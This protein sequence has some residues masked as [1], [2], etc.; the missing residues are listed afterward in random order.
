MS[1]CAVMLLI[2]V[3]MSFGQNCTQYG[4]ST[5][6]AG[7][8]FVRDESGY[9]Q[10]IALKLQQPI[11]TSPD[12]RKGLEW[13]RGETGV[14]EVQA[15]VYGSDEVSNALRDR[16]ER[17]VG[18]QV[19][20]RGIL[21]PAQT[22]YHHTNVQVGVESVD[23]VDSAGQTALRT[24]TA[25]FQPKVVAAYEVTIN[26]ASRLTVEA[27]DAASKA[28]LIPAEEY[29]PHWMTGGEVVYANCLDGYER[30][31]ISTTD[32]NG[33]ICFDDDLCGFS[34]FPQKPIIIKFRCIK[35]P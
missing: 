22:G 31:L 8:L 7:R 32:K 17:L 26:A 5:S 12:R 9:N 28:P 25:K 2:S 29:A 14:K 18:H 33:G 4:T 3:A 19:E 16:L 27:Q 15:G 21:F 24:P 34:A 20:L 30:K 1:K 23:P 13:E 11:C 6:L 10:F 35:K